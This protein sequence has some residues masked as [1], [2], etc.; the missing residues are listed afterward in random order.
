MRTRIQRFLSLD[1]IDPQYRVRRG[2]SCAECCAV[3]VFPGRR[4]NEIIDAAAGCEH[5]FVAN[6]GSLH[7]QFRHAIERRNLSAA[8]SGGRDVRVVGSGDA[9]AL[10]LLA[11]DA[12]QLEFYSVRAARWVTEQRADLG[13]RPR[14]SAAR[15]TR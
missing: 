4:A 5:R 10:V 11:L 3:T 14:C 13:A 15:S 7:G 8:L 1:S 2:T 12:T 9:L 6:S